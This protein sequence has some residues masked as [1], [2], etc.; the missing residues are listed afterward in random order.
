METP[1]NAP[2]AP[3]TY[4]PG[5][6][7]IYSGRL[8]AGSRSRGRSQSH[9]RNL[10]DGGATSAFPNAGPTSALLFLLA[11]QFSP[12]LL[13]VSQSFRIQLSRLV[14]QATRKRSWIAGRLVVWG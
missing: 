2:H 1:R 9:E 11:P 8:A 6:G 12:L 4:K 13:A 14:E 10:R 7:Q 3:R 5:A